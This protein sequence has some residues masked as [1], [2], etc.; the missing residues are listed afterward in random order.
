M[1]L[2]WLLLLVPVF[3]TLQILYHCIKWLLSGTAGIAG[4]EYNKSEEPVWFWLTIAGSV[5]LVVIYVFAGLSLYVSASAPGAEF[6]RYSD[7][8][9]L[10]LLVAQGVGLSIRKKRG[11]PKSGAA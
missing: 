11:T 4:F 2:A 1:K 8:L 6:N 9:I 3:L 7:F 5:V 10:C